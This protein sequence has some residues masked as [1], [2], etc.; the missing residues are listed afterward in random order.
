MKGPLNP[1]TARIKK[2]GMTQRSWALKHQFNPQTVAHVINGTGGQVY[3]KAG[4]GVSGQI[5]A[6][7]QKDGFL[8]DAKQ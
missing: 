8:E 2:A 5:V 1:I 4:I 7:L 6:Q 3:G